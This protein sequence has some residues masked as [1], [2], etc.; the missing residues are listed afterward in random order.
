MYEAP[1]TKIKDT[2]GK[3]GAF[4]LD[5]RDLECRFRLIPPNIVPSKNHRNIIWSKTTA[6]V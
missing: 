4:G 2:P 3:D 1:Q 6:F 5:V